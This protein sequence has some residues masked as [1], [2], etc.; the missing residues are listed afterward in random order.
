MPQ[1]KAPIA[2]RPMDGGGANQAA[3]ERLEKVRLFKS[4]ARQRASSNGSF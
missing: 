4:L 3:S 2:T 1:G